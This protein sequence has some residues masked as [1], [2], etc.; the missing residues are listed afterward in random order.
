[1]EQV[2]LAQVGAGVQGCDPDAIAVVDAK[3]RRVQRVPTGVERGQQLKR[4]PEGAQLALLS[5]QI[6]EPALRVAD[7]E[8]AANY[9]Q[10]CPLPG[11][12]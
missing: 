12:R 1:M 5:E 8:E 9:F 7:G 2:L 11:R 10:A 4:R 3:R 6:V